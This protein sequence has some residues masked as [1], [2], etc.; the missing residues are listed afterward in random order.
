M[1][2]LVF[3]AICVLVGQTI[4]QAKSQV[5]QEVDI[6]R[7]NYDDCFYGS[8]IAQIKDKQNFDVNQKAEAAFLACATEEQALRDTAPR[9]TGIADDPIIN[10]TVLKIKIQLKNFARDIVAHPQKY[11]K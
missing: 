3:I 5:S 4:T 11:A 10:A 6:A 7:K 1:M 9:P 8:L 2:K